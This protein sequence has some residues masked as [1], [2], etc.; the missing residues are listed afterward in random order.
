LI[1]LVNPFSGV[2]G[3][4]GRGSIQRHAR[5]SVAVKLS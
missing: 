5:T 4:R 2:H 3:A 1:D